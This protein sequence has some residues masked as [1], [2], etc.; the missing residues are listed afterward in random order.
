M[1]LF[2]ISRTRSRAIGERTDS[3]NKKKATAGF[4]KLKIINC[5]QA[6]VGADAVKSAID[7]CNQNKETNHLINNLPY[8]SLFAVL[9]IA[10]KCNEP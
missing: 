6:T 7:T 5:Q 2:R 3:N 1:K 8:S 4:Y 9:T 10:A